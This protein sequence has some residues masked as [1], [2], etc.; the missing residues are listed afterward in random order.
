[1]KE[2]KYKIINSE[3]EKK[4]YRVTLLSA[5]L[6]GMFAHLFGI[7]NVIK[8]YDNMCIFKGYGDGIRSGRWFLSII[9]EGL[10]K[11]WGGN[12]NLQFYNGIITILL[13]AVAAYVIVRTFDIRDLTF[14]AMWAAVFIAFPSVTAMELYVYTAPY[15][16]VAILMVTLAVYFTKEYKYGFVAGVIL[17]ACAI[18]IYQAYFPIMIGLFVSIMID[19]AIES[20]D[21]L[22]TLILTGIKY[23]GTLL[24]SIGVYF[25]ASKVL[26][27]LAG[28]E[29]N[30]YQGIDQM[31]K[32]NLAELPEM[33]KYLY[34]SFIHIV[35]EDYIGISATGFVRLMILLLGAISGIMLIY[36]IVKKKDAILK[37][38]KGLLL[39]LLIIYPIS[40]NGIV[41]MCYH[42]YKHTLMVHS[43]VLIFLMPFLISKHWEKTV[44][45]RGSIVKKGIVVVSALLF[46]NYSYQANTAYTA[47]YYKNQQA[48]NYWGSVLTQVRMQEGFTTDLKWAFIGEVKDELYWNPWEQDYIIGGNSNNVL[49]AYST[50]RMIMQYHGYF[51]PYASIEEKE[52]L[53]QS[54]EVKAM[55]DYPNDGSI[56]IIGDTI[57]IKFSDVE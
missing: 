15:Y 38:N 12:W 56:K 22:K 9:G 50:N 7:V 14:C 39:A 33:L 28:L 11:I 3:F 26:L 29:L 6:F 53:E 36:V 18:G 31:G 1:M 44:G 42:S 35:T 23:L 24:M 5:F 17:G 49:N 10:A 20:E 51:L 13:L 48:N 55:A 40:V 4:R 21:D 41:L 16:A 45:Q 2:R 8:N 19:K 30:D 34:S 52:K 32:I 27:K 46:L 54:E 47:L 43:L 57:V 37:K 25:V